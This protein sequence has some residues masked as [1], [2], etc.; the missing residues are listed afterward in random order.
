MYTE[1]IR[2]ETGSRFFYDLVHRFLQRFSPRLNGDI[3]ISFIKKDPLLIQLRHALPCFQRNTASLQ[4][5]QPFFD[6]LQRN[7]K[8]DDQSV[9]LKTFHDPGI[10]DGAASRRDDGIAAFN[11]Q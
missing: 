9:L 8:I 11:G 6:L 2:R 7:V 10:I 5:S 3:R 4:I 1:G